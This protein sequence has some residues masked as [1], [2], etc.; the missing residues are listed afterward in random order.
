MLRNDSKIRGKAGEWNRRPLCMI[1]HRSARL[2]ANLKH[3]TEGG[4]FTFGSGLGMLQ[5]FSHPTSQ[6]LRSWSWRVVRD[7]RP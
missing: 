2:D 6:E 3:Y 1:V 5:V 7:G 4:Y